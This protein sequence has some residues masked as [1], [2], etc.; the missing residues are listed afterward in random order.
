MSPDGLCGGGH[1]VPR[2]R[3][4]FSKPSCPVTPVEGHPSQDGRLEGLLGE[5]L[6]SPDGL[7][8]GG[9]KVPRRRRYFSK[10]NSAPRWPSARMAGLL[11]GPKGP[12][13]WAGEALRSP[14]WGY[15][16]KPNSP[17][18]AVRP[19]GRLAFWSERAAGLGGG[20]LKVPR[21][22]LFFQAE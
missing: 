16:S 3:G 10:P 11:V 13:A 22:G 1:K 5:T 18:M 17:E 7:G 8:G 12:L 21:M 20:G 15:F 19:D 14:A 9:H 2:T 6:I 4:N